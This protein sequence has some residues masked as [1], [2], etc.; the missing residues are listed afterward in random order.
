VP[1]EVD[2]GSPC[3]ERAEFGDSAVSPYLLPYRPGE[4]YLLAQ[5]YCRSDG[6]HRNQLAYDFAMP[7]GRDVL[8][9]RAGEVVAVKEDSPDDGRG[10]GRHNFVFVQHEDGT[11]A[12]YAHLQQEGVLVGVGDT[13]AA[14][15]VIAL[16]GN[17]GLTGRPHLHFGV[18]RWW[19]PQEGFDVPVN[20]RNAAGRLDPHGGLIEGLV[21]EALV[22]GQ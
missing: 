8:A 20:F 9:A 3:L 13:V 19:P 16:S 1:D 15:D 22:E 4:F 2:P 7:V 18:Y 6:G 12:F 10:R 14:G 21:Y 17:S 5:S 11:V